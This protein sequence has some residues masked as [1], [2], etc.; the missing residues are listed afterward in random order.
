[1]DLGHHPYGPRPMRS[2]VCSATTSSTGLPL[3]SLRHR[4]VHLGIALG[5]LADHFLETHTDAHDV[6]RQRRGGLAA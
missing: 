3:V 1:M 5:R 4:L 2:R 6:I